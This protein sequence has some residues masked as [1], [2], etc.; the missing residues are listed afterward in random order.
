MSFFI[1]NI[2]Y[3]IGVFI[4]TLNA[5]SQWKN[6]IASIKFQTISASRIVVIDSGSKDKTVSLAEESGF[7]VLRIPREKFNHGATRNIGIRHLS[8][9]DIIIFLTQDTILADVKS[10]EKLIVPFSDPSV[11]CV[12]GRQ[13]PHSYANPLAKHARIYNYPPRDIVK[14]KSLVPLIGFKVS[15]I[16]NAYAAYRTSHLITCGSFPENVVIAE[17]TFLASN[18]IMAGYKI[19]YKG[20]SAVYHSHNYSFTQEFRRYFDTGVFHSQ[21]NWIRKEFGEPTGEGM[22]YVVSEIRYLLAH[23]PM[24]ILPSLI[25]SLAKIV[26]FRMGIKYKYLP[27]F[28][29]KF[30]SMNK[31]YWR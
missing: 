17:D 10:F 24:W 20:D 26:G 3:R 19:V 31:E 23:Y 14:D 22:K 7:D 8:N 13:L 1:L 30:F 21:N 6:L 16:S 15:H 29:R 28:L 9:C 11:S 5:G 18:L 2:M 12:Y 27:T 25:N 4:P